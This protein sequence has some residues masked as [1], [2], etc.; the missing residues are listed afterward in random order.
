M[1][2]KR[3]LDPIKQEAHLTVDGHAVT[4]CFSP[5]YN[6]TLASLVKE[7]LIDSFLRRNGIGADEFKSEL[8]VG[9]QVN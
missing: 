5:D 3:I 4:I 8:A 9:Q 7:T 2:E 6:P 1:I